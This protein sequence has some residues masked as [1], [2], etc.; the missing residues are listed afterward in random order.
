MLRSRRDRREV[1]P[2]AV[3]A[4]LLAAP[5][6]V[7]AAAGAP[8]VG[9][10]IA[11][12]GGVAG[13]PAALLAPA[14]AAVPLATSARRCAHARTA[15]ARLSRATARR[16][17][18]CAINRARAAH[19][20]A[21]FAGEHHLRSAARRQAADMV[22]HHYF[23]HQRAGGPSLSERLRAAGWTGRAAGEAI[24]WGCGSSG[25]AAATVRAWLHSPPH[26]AIVLSGAYRGAGIGVAARAPASCSPGATWVLDAGV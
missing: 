20:L 12:T 19:G 22:R 8:V 15:P 17:L 13:D 11:S 10:V 18:L 4:A 26:R 6:P 23:G 9:S 2:F 7:A 16:A 25:S 24:A 14:E 21:G 3:L 1:L 5:A